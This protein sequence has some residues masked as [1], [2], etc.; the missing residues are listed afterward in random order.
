MGVRAGADYVLLYPLRDN[1]LA[2]VVPGEKMGSYLG[3]RSAIAGAF[4]L[5]TYLAMGTVID[6]T[7]AGGSFQGYG[8]ILAI[9]FL[10]STLNIVFYCGVRQPPAPKVVETG[11]K[12]TFVSFLKSARKSHLG[13]FIVFISLYTF[14]VNLAGPFFAS[15]MLGDL[16]FNMMTYTAI[17]GCEFV[18]RIISLTFWGKYVDKV[19]S[20][21]VLSIVAYAIHFACPSSGYS[22]RA[23]FI[24]APCRCCVALSGPPS[25][26]ACRLSSIKPPSRNNG[27]AISFTIEAS[28][29]FPWR[30]AH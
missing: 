18:A 21:R 20:L 29:L 13:T 17:V 16:K 24:W 25:T 28:H 8:F 27:C 12:L 7:A 6:R 9:A 2:G 5:M 4:Y 3:W 30:W 23:L 19:G 11:P 15:Y 1:W 26:F 14:A 10:A 22:R